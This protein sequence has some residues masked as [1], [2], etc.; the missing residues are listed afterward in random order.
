LQL[1]L[2]I[3]NLPFKVGFWFLGGMAIA[4][5][6]LITTRLILWLKRPRKQEAHT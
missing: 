6:A 4:M 1:T 5:P 3:T 2:E